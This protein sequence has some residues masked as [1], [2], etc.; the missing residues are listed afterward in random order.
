MKATTPPLRWR[1]ARSRTGSRNWAHA[2]PCERAW[3]NDPR[4]KGLR[5]QIR[6]QTIGEIVRDLRVS[7]NTVRKFICGAATEFKY[8][9]GVQL[10]PALGR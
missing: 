2:V 9:R 7:R 10:H 6:G 3:N 8:A 4:I 1:C 5:V